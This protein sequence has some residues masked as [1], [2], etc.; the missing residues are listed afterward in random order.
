M[1]VSLFH[2]GSSKAERYRKIKTTKPLSAIFTLFTF[3]FFALYSQNMKR[4]MDLPI[5]P[6]K[7]DVSTPNR[8]QDLL[9]A[10]GDLPA[11]TKMDEEKKYEHLILE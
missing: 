3:K 11:G 5:S 6:E 1:C 2:F 4:R 7:Q 9:E 8:F 10:H